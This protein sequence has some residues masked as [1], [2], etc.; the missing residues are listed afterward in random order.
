[1][2]RV[3]PVFCFLQT[4][5]RNWGQQS[6]GNGYDQQQQGGYPHGSYGQGRMG[7]PDDERVFITVPASAVGLII[8]RG[9]FTLRICEIEY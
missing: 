7:R 2:S 5:G 9:E 1:M 4:G 6:Y 3:E 8:G